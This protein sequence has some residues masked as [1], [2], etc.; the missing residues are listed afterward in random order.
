[1]I[2]IYLQEH[3]ADAHRHAIV[4]RK[5][6]LDLLHVRHLR[7]YGHLVAR[8]DRFARAAVDRQASTRNV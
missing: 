7:S 6:N 2:G 1:L 4:V 5:D 3:I 8:E